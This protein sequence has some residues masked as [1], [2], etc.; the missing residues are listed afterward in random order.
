MWSPYILALLKY[1][2]SALVVF[3]S[4]VRRFLWRF[5]PNI[6][7]DRS[8]Q[9]SE[10][11]STD[12]WWP[13]FRELGGFVYREWNVFGRLRQ[14]W[15]DILTT[16][17]LDRRPRPYSTYSQPFRPVR[18]IEASVW[19]GTNN[20]STQLRSLSFLGIFVW[21]LPKHTGE[22]GRRRF[23]FVA[24][25]PPRYPMRAMVES[26]SL[27]YSSR[28]PRRTNA[29]CWPPQNESSSLDHS[30]SVLGLHERKNATCWSPRLTNLLFTY[31]VV[32]LF[33]TV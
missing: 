21:Q 27:D 30:S 23:Q 33:H 20:L 1:I 9:V 3:L 5:V 8:T 18:E 14:A 28:P 22:S 32:L 29:T 17:A 15:V 10:P 19:A 13:Q 16:D 2:P 26:S 6:E 7:C 31:C 12:S 24:S 25:A 11:N 4:V